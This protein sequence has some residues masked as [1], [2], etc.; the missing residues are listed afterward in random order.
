[1]RTLQRSV[2]AFCALALGAGAAQATVY[3]FNF[4]IEGSQEVPVVVT[5][6][7]GTGSVTYDDVSNEL[8]WTIT[9][10][11]LTGTATLSHF[12]GPAPVGVNAGVQVNIADL[13][14][15]I[16][17]PMVGMTTITEVQETDLL[18]GLWYVNIH[19]TFAGGGEIRGQVVPEPA[20][21]A[22]LAG[23]GLLVLRRRR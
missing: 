4:P 19:S 3:N 2:G 23:G 21:L 10:S 17:S 18:D 11:G 22:L 9:Y 7:S 16:A 12:H 13:S 5:P 8:S 14:G 15:G 20:S 6:G 1:M